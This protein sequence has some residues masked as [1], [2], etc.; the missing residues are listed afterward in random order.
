MG[1]FKD[2]DDESRGGLLSGGGGGSLGTPSHDQ[3]EDVPSNDEGNMVVSG[4]G[5]ANAGDEDS[6]TAAGDRGLG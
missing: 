3:V 4:G 2:D 5:V 6:A 1:I